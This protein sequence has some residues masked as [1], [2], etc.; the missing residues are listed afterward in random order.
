MIIGLLAAEGRRGSTRVD[1]ASLRR[2]GHNHKGL[3]GFFSP[4]PSPF[5]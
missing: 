4:R 5:L 2:Y 3:S 1:Y